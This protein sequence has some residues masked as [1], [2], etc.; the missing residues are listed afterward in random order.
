MACM[1]Q[2][3]QRQLTMNQSWNKQSS[4]SVL[5]A[6]QYHS[7][8]WIYN[9]V[10]ENIRYYITNF[11]LKLHVFFRQWKL[12]SD[13]NDSMQKIIVSAEVQPMVLWIMYKC[14]ITF[15]GCSCVM[16]QSLLH[17]G[18]MFFSNVFLIIKI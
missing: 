4:Y 5:T 15:Q 13:E 7:V 6:V 14:Q 12:Y 3:W 8:W 1:P 11:N 18:Y 17:A 16:S 9:W 10:T 2:I